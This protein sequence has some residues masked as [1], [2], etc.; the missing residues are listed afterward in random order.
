MSVSCFDGIM[1]ENVTLRVHWAVLG[2][3]G[4]ELY[5]V[6]KSNIVEPVQGN[7]YRDLVDTQSRLIARFSKE[8]AQQLDAIIIQHSRK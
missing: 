5:A 7:S 3:Y 2:D 1:G 8:I 6:Q 4:R